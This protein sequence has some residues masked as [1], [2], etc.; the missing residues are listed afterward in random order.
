MHVCVCLSPN[1]QRVNF[2]SDLSLVDQVF[3]HFVQ[4]KENNHNNN[5]NE[6]KQQ[7]QQQP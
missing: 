1:K 5:S 4:A 2:R 6:Q 3:G 7:Q